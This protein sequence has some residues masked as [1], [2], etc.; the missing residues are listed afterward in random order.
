METNDAVKNSRPS[1]SSSLIGKHK[2]AWDSSKKQE[3]AEN[4]YN[5]QNNRTNKNVRYHKDRRKS[6]LPRPPS[7]TSKKAWDEPND[8][9]KA[10][11]SGMDISFNSVELHE[12]NGHAKVQI[13]ECHDETRGYSCTEIMAT[14][15]KVFRSKKFKSVK[16]EQL[17]QRYFF[18]LNRSNLSSYLLMVSLLCL[19][20]ILCHYVSGHF[21]IYTG[22]CLGLF[23]LV[24]IAIAVVCNRN[25]F[26]QKQLKISCYSVLTIMCIVISID[27]FNT[28]PQDAST[29][30]WTTLFIVYM[31]Y[32]LLPLRMR[33]AV[34]GSIVLGLVQ[35]ICVAIV[36]K[37]DSFLWRQIL[38]NT[39]LFL[40]VNLAGVFTHYPTEVAQR[41]A[42]LETRRCI[43]ARLTTSRE[44]QQQERLLL[45]VLPRH[46]AMEMKADIA[47][48]KECVQFHKIYIQC[49]NDVSILFADIEGFT[50]LSSQCTAQELV[51]ILNELF[52][53][54][55]CLAQENHCLRIKILGD[56]YYCVSGL[57]E[58]RSDHS[59]C[60]VEMGLDM[61]DAIGVVR[62]VTKVNV[63]MR[64]GIHSGRVHCGVLGLRKW[65]FDV[66]S[67][68]VTLA[69]TME[70]GGLSGRVHITDVTKDYL[71]G[72]YEVE[73]GHGMDRNS[74]LRDH[75]INT[76]LIKPKHPRVSLN[77]VNSEKPKPD[78]AA[79]Q[80]GAWDS[81]RP[82]L[83]LPSAGKE[84][85]GETREKNIHQKLGLEEEQTKS[86]PEDEVDEFLGRAIDARSID[87]LRS[88][89][90][91]RITLTFRKPELE[92]KA[93]HC[94]LLL[95]S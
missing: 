67:N 89:H 71:N 11:N 31:T 28:E 36:N 22:V 56:C 32:A 43:K 16:L 77:N 1:S 73:P 70:A 53:R 83:F 35:I 81:D 51:K 9:E 61:I 88:D 46:V 68:D 19:V 7:T 74:Y 91:K 86:N 84:T 65:Q 76:W 38:S 64:V 60:C 55:D 4:G 63:N 52:A 17:Y 20:L 13:L 87:R 69:N 42:F 85:H 39:I 59:H 41:Q 6:E 23:V 21:N 75:N 40:A 25:S 78:K 3:D 14:V 54:F 93:R 90:V 49:H 5:Q 44:N 79:T 47:I 37:D 33:L 27:V 24:F 8:V 26:T 94:F 30:V 92:I 34:F 80:L 72:D 57:P 62:D 58:A 82:F 18:G 10:S 95:I 45:S 66:W 29:G 15:S 2:K 50:K 48:D 12:K